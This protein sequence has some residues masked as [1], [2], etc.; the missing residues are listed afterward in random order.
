M[1]RLVNF[2]LSLLVLAGLA[3][4]GYFYLATEEIHPC[5]AALVRLGPHNAETTLALQFKGP[6][7]NL[8]TIVECYAV[9]FDGASEAPVSTPIDVPAP[10]VQ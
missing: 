10:A 4:H 7:R 9:A 1:G 3:V 8:D 2:L 5:R 6:D